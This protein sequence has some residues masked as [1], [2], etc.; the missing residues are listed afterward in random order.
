MQTNGSN[1]GLI[2]GNG[3]TGMEGTSDG[4]EKS[5]QQLTKAVDENTEA[6]NVVTTPA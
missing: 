6:R 1:T 3:S 2:S 5:L 4:L